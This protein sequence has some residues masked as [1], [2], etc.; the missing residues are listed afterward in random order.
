MNRYT[1][2]TLFGPQGWSLWGMAVA[3]VA[4]G[5]RGPRARR[6]VG[7][8]LGLALGWALAMYVSPLGK[9]LIEPLEARFAVP[10]SVAG[11][12]DILVLTGGEHLAASVRHRQAEYGETGDRMVVGAML[13]HA[14]PGARL[15]SVGG[16]RSEPGEPRDVD[17]MG[18]AWREL[19]V[20]ARRIVLVGDTVDTCGN[21]RGLAA[22]L[23]R[24]ARPLL[25]TSAFHMPRAVGCLRAAG[26]EVTPYPADFVNGDGLGLF[27]GGSLN[28]SLNSWR[29]D[30][31]LHEYVGLL[32]YRLTGR[33]HTLW[34]GPMQSAKNPPV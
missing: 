13:A 6:L 1:L 31:A 27:E 24:D 12:T 17:W 26:V 11:T 28:F 25:V 14:F 2:W 16:I 3:M 5:W 20:D 15:W 30:V 7:W 29:T 18:L 21:A 8:S 22:R 9:W 19:G 32:Y 4:L 34:P 10:V 33:I 23:K